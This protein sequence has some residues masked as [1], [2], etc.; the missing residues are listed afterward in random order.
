MRSSVPFFAALF[1][2]FQLVMAVPAVLPMVYGGL[3]SN[4]LRTD[5][6]NRIRL[7]P[8]YVSPA[9]RSGRISSPDAPSANGRNVTV[10]NST[11]SF[12][13]GEANGQNGGSSTSADVTGRSSSTKLH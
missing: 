2:A 13:N 4:Q 1:M 3:V 7:A 6:F 12:N 9:R 8:G 11:D 5:Q 10:G